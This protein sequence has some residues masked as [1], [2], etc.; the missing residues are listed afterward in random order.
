[1]TFLEMVRHT[2]EKANVPLSAEEIWEKGLE[3]KFAQQ[4]KTSGKTPQMTVAALLYVNIR[5]DESTSFV[6]S[7]KR[8]TRFGLSSW[9][10]KELL[11]APP[12]IV[13]PHRAQYK[14]KDLHQILAYYAYNYL[15][16]LTRTIN[17]KI[18]KS[19]VKGK[20]EW[21]HPDMVGLD[22]S[23][24]KDFSKGVL[25]FSRQINQTPVGVFSFEIKRK[26]E[27]SNLR[28]C[29]FQAVSN[30]RWANKGYLVCAEIDTNDTELIE[31]LSRLAL[32]YGIGV[33]QLNIE[34][35][36]ESKVLSEAH[37]NETIE[38][39]FVNYLFEL[40]NDY[41]TFIE[42]SIDILKTEELYREKFDKVATQPEIMDFVE[43][44]KCFD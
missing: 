22:I 32:A 35:P 19:G 7:S 4:V 12:K 9:G 11:A 29:Y 8:P 36:D 37:Y 27:F 2:L 21:L 41:K 10:D 33:I 13:E 44:F 15:K 40:N 3:F 38:W 18:S 14:E 5:D 42:A 30:S 23:S 17:D 1:M 26:I 16:I 6:I 25:S 43:G 28:E 31:E 24:I 39:G 34:N 20:N